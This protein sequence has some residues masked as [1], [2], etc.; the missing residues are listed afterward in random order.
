MRKVLIISAVVLLVLAGGGVG[1]YLLM[2]AR[3]FQLFGGLT[4]RVDTEQKVVALTFDDG[5]SDKAASIEKALADQHVPATF[6]LIGD[7]MEK[8]PGVAEQLAAQG[9]QLANHS[10]THSRM[11]FVGA[12]FV[13]SEIE[14]TDALIRNAGYQGDIV[15]RPPYS[16]KLFQLPRYLA[17]HDRRTVTWDVEPDSDSGDPAH[18]DPNAIVRTTL[19]QVRPGSIILLHPWNA[20][21]DAD[22]AA[23][24]RIVDGLRAKGYRF[25]T[26]NELLVTH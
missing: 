8:H 23:L 20:D 5:P 18:D 19:D 6:F 13:A 26:V 12:D 21:H 10:Y 24:P 22:L 2:N 11:V 7:E 16:K 15:F 4:Y 25:V 9:H 3:T 14:R 17:D 1:L